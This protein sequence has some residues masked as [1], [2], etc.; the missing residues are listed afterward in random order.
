VVLD[1]LL[2]PLASATITPVNELVFLDIDDRRS[3][4][5]KDARWQVSSKTRDSPSNRNSSAP[6]CRPRFPLQTSHFLA[7]NLDMESVSTP[8]TVSEKLYQKGP[9]DPTTF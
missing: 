9:Y 3:V 8:W 7:Y 6:L 1:L 4:V 2:S 5:T